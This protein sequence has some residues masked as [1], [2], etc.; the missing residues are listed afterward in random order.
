MAP[1]HPLLDSNHPHVIISEIFRFN[2]TFARSTWP[3]ELDSSK[4]ATSCYRRR[5]RWAACKPI[6]IICVKATLCSF[7]L[8]ARSISQ[9]NDLLALHAA[10]RVELARCSHTSDIQRRKYLGQ[11]EG[12]SNKPFLNTP[13]PAPETSISCLCSFS[14]VRLR[15]FQ[16]SDHRFSWNL[17][18]VL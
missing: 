15:T 7:C 10:L 12:H 13:G 6:D 14:R 5:V 4:C 3:H 1:H 11:D 16:N 8:Q 2:T 17:Q 9:S 18:P